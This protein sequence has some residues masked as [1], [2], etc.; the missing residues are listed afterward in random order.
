MV[1]L[2]IVLYGYSIGKELY[3]VG[4]INCVALLKL[5]QKGIVFHVLWL[6]CRYPNTEKKN[7]FTRQISFGRQVESEQ[8]NKTDECRADYYRYYTENET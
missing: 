1:N 3:N 7:R 4:Y 2:N 8:V 5:Q 6:E